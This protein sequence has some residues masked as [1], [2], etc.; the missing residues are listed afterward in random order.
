V[1]ADPGHPIYA[2]VDER[3]NELVAPLQGRQAVYVDRLADVP[4]RLHFFELSIRGQTSVGTP[5]TLQAELPVVREEIGGGSVSRF[6]S[7]AADMLIDLACHPK[8]P[9]RLAALEA[10]KAAD[11]LKTTLQ[12]E[13]RK[14]FQEERWRYADVCRAYLERSFDARTRAAQDRVFSLKAREAESPEVALARQRA[15]QGRVD[16]KRTRTERISGLDRL[17]IA[18]PGPMRHIASAFILPSSMEGIE[19]LTDEPDPETRRRVELA[20]EDV[21]IA[22]GTARGWETE[23]VGHLNIGFDIRSLRPTD[24][25]TG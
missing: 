14:A 2:T 13:R 21:V 16:L 8:P 17:V 15:E 23:G 19:E 20:A 1:L 6:S 4:Y 12:M 22:Y 18:R 25:Q 10:E 7:V 11:F 24:A 3:L 5:T 9:E